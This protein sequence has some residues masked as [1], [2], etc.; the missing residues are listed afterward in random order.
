MGVME[1]QSLESECLEPHGSQSL[2][3][4][5]ASVVPQLRA[6]RSRRALRDSTVW[7]EHGQ[8]VARVTRALRFGQPD[9][10]CAAQ[11]SRHEAPEGRPFL[12]VV[13]WNIERGKAAHAQVAYLAAHPVLRHADVLML[14]E[15]DVGM[16]RSGDIDVVR[17]FGD[18]LGF[19]HVFGNSYL[20]LDSGNARDRAAGRENTLGLAGNAILSRFPLLRAENVSLAITKEK[21][22][23]SEKRLGHKKALWA[24]VATPLGPLAVASVHLDSSCAPAAR[25][26]QLDDLLR[27]LEQ[28]GVAERCLVGGD[29]NTTTYDLASLPRLSW[30]IVQKLVRG[31]FPHAIH[32]YVHP[33]ELYEKPVFDVLAA[34]GLDWDRFNAPAVGTS[35]YEVG[36][37]DSESKVRDYLPDVFVRLLAWRLRPWSGVAPLKIDWF[38]G[39]GLRVLEAEALRDGDRIA[40]APAAFAKPRHEG[41]L[42][43]DHDPI[44]VDVA[45]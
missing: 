25:A 36:T 9:A 21:F 29:L 30:N 4:G 6:I 18:G 40:T 31:G 11:Q 16:A 14:N 5:L 39:R 38:A 33:F 34:H 13:H 44:V 12:R 23:S 22:H 28:R 37:F 7:R 8:E 32:H 43:S 24:Q 42:L 2:Q 17:V 3:H 19:Y 27:E 45:F 41:E 26:A 20:C 1:D 10:V 35:R 15:V